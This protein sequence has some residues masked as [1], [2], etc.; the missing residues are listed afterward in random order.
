MKKP[1]ND[2]PMCPLC[3]HDGRKQIT[4]RPMEFPECLRAP[5]LTL[6][7]CPECGTIFA[8]T[9][10]EDPFAVLERAV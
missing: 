2:A 1:K 4:E 8:D 3:G 7:K 10:A 6:F 5:T 9:K